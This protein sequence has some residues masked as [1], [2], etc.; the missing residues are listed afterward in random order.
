MSGNT[1]IKM[2]KVI[3]TR[4]PIIC[5]MIGASL[6]KQNEIV[7]QRSPRPRAA[8]ELQINVVLNPP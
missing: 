6:G 7:I 5:A 1:R 8:R 2:P 3:K 4:A